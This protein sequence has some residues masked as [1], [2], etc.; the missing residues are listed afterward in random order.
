[1]KRLIPFVLAVLALSCGKTEPQTQQ[2]GGGSKPSVQEFII[3]E[4]NIN[5]PY[6][7]GT[8]FI[9][10]GVV[11]EGLSL[12][13]TAKVRV[14]PEGVVNVTLKDDGIEV[15]PIAMGSV[16][17]Y[18]NPV[19]GPAAEKSISVRVSSQIVKV[20]INKQGSEI[21]F[22]TF[23]DIQLTAT[24]T[25]QDNE[26]A[27]ARYNWK[28]VSGDPSIS[29]TPSGVLKSSVGN[30]S[31]KVRCELAYNPSVYDEATVR[32][33]WAAK[34]IQA[35][36]NFEN[37]QINIGP[38]S[39]VTLK[40]KII[41]EEAPQEVQF[42]VEDDRGYLT[43][44]YKQ[45]FTVTK[46]SISG[47]YPWQLKL[48]HVAPYEKALVLV[49]EDS[50]GAKKLR[51]TVYADEFRRAQAKPG[52]YIFYN[53]STGKFRISDCGRRYKDRFVTTEKYT[54][55][56]ES[57]EEYIGVLAR[58][59]LPENDFLGSDSPISRS[60]LP[61]FTGLTSGHGLV[62]SAHL[63]PES[64]WQKVCTKLT[65]PSHYGYQVSRHIHN[66]VNPGLSQDSKVLPVE[67]IYKY[68]QQHPAGSTGWFLPG[69]DDIGLNNNGF[70]YTDAYDPY[71]VL[72]LDG[73]KDDEGNN[74]PYWTCSHFTNGNATD[75]CHCWN[76]PVSSN[77]QRKNEP[78]P[79]R[80]AL[81]L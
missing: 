17:I 66:N 35:S 75:F 26:T 73:A 27:V 74:I 64:V 21:V 24:A 60:Q 30:V 65:L 4:S 5:I 15:T 69:R 68:Q 80:A 76:S 70:G 46:S 67:E 18:I 53:A 44:G 10:V 16:G 81:W 48:E 6:D 55:E 59:G 31:A 61:G 8:V 2:Q 54:P 52:D 41:P 50:R 19:S 9:P 25:N 71:F 40:F 34:D 1:M 56:P 63:F 38:S 23:E 39:V 45:Y 14:N 37:N 57:G 3:N 58:A 36:V 13:E 43:N 78:I 72:S 42:Y 33:G 22:A 28:I 20:S 47:E 51:Y 49:V 32:A 62:I 7:V 12:K 77:T 29:V 79:Y 11:P